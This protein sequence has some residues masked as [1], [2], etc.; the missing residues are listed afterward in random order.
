MSKTGDE[1]LLIDDS[2]S[3]IHRKLKKAV[4]A[5]DGHGLSLGVDNLFLLLKGFGT[6]EQLAYFNDAMRTN[7]IKFSELK[8]TLATDISE[9]FTEF[10]ERKQALLADPAQIARILANG[11]QQARTQAEQTMIEVRQKVGLL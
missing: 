7:T 11:A 1:G 4:T 8:E 5:S 6:T 2:P 3:E 9:Y 10:R